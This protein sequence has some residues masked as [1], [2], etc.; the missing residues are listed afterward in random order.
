[1]VSWLF[2]RSFLPFVQCC[3]RPG[4]G[5]NEGLPSPL[6]ALEGIQPWDY[7]TQ[8]T[9]YIFFTLKSNIQRSNQV[10]PKVFQF[11]NLAAKNNIRNLKSDHLV[12]SLVAPSLLDILI[13]QQYAVLPIKI[14]RRLWRFSKKVLKVH[15]L[16]EN[17]FRQL[18][19]GINYQV[20]FW[21]P[22]AQWT[23]S[24]NCNW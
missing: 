18:C 12:L 23:A 19:I 10:F 6:W 24:A 22:T 13:C 4:L 14:S 17:G 15:I 16:L 11:L 7:W 9:V 2:L 20:T 1:M 21:M 3:V 5:H 8:C